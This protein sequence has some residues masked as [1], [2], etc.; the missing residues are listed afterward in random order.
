MSK[1]TIKG[2]VIFEKYRIAIYLLSLLS[3]LNIF[4]LSWAYIWV[5][6]QRVS[7]AIL[8]LPLTFGSSEKVDSELSQRLKIDIPQQHKFLD[9]ISNLDLIQEKLIIKFIDDFFRVKLKDNASVWCDCSKG[10]D[11]NGELHICSSVVYGEKDRCSICCNSSTEVYTYFKDNKLDIYKSIEFNGLSQSVEIL[12]MNKIFSIEKGTFKS[13]WIVKIRRDSFTN[14]SISEIYITIRKSPDYDYP[15]Y[16]V[17]DIT[18]AK[19]L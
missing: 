5:R 4:L 12:D 9:S 15:G 11:R 6:H 19:L 7:P 3:I 2:V 13:L 1:G 8:T 17:S 14:S 18:E 16:Y 10:I